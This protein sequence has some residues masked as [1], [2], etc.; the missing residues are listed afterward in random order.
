MILAQNVV[1]SITIWTWNTEFCQRS[2]WHFEA[3]VKLNF[4]P[5]GASWLTFKQGPADHDCGP[6]HTHKG[7]WKVCDKNNSLSPGALAFY[8]VLSFLMTGFA[9]RVYAGFLYLSL[10]SGKWTKFSYTQLY[11]VFYL[12]N[13]PRWMWSNASETEEIH[14]FLDQWSDVQRVLK[15]NCFTI[16]LFIYLSL[17]CFAQ[18]LQAD[19]S[20]GLYYVIYCWMGHT[21]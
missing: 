9:C 11:L 16:G 3:L 10:S 15:S 13:F 7:E 6:D 8:L 20:Q 4:L 17:F 18:S 12:N 1:N 5:Q 21:G 2:H 14:V 19:C